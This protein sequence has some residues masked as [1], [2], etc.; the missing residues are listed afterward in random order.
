MELGKFLTDS[1]VEL[2][3]VPRAKAQAGLEAAV[4]AH[5]A[6]LKKGDGSTLRSFQHFDSRL[7]CLSTFGRVA[8]A[9]G[10]GFGASPRGG[11]RFCQGVSL[12]PAAGSEA[13]ALEHRGLSDSSSPPAQRARG[14]D[15]V[16]GASPKTA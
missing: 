5:T 1:R 15:A 12:G 7:H 2:V 6:L 11:E 4:L 13:I 3:E 8:R 10:A 9:F 14:D 16:S